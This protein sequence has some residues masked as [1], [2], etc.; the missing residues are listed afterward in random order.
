MVKDAY[1]QREIQLAITQFFEPDPTWFPVGIQ[2]IGYKFRPVHNIP[3]ELTGG[4]VSIFL[5]NFKERVRT[6]QPERSRFN[7]LHI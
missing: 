6:A 3:F 1:F 5:G 2:C 7:I 4:M